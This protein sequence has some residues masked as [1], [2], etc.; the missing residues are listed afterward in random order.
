MS[1]YTVALYQDP[2]G[3]RPPVEPVLGICVSGGGSR[4]MT[5]TLGQLS[6][7]NTLPDPLK[8]SQTLMQRVS[9]L[10][11]VSGGSWAAVPY[12]YLPATI[13]GK[14]VADS[15]ILIAP[16]APSALVKGKPSD[17]SPANV[18]HLAPLCLGTV[19]GGFN[20]EA[21]AGFALH[22]IKLWVW[23]KVPLSWLWIVAVGQFV[24]QKF[25]L[26]EAGYN[27]GVQPSTFFSLSADY[28]STA[29]VPANPQLKPSDFYTA[30]A[31]RPTLVVNFNLLQDIANAPQVPVQATPIATGLPGQSPDG[32]ITGGG[33]CE[34]FGFGSTVSG[35]SS[36]ATATAILARRYSLCDITGCSSAFFAQWLQQHLGPHL[37]AAIA[38][39]EAIPEKFGLAALEIPQVQTKLAELKTQ[40]AADETVAV[41]PQYTVWPVG[42]AA[43]A[44]TS[45]GFSDGGSFDNTGIL[46]LLARTTGDL[47]V[48][49]F[50]NCEAPLAMD[51]KS[52][53]VIVDDQLS[54]LF[55]FAAYDA[56]TGRYP[57]YG[58]MQP[59]QPMSYVQLFADPAA[60]FAELR[61]T[62]AANS[63]AGGSALGNGIA[64][65]RQSLVTIANPVAAIT[66][67]RN[68]DVLWV[69]N[70]PVAAW[71]NQI[72]D[73]AL[74]ADLKQ[75]QGANPSGPL[76]NFPN[77][78]TAS[79]LQ[80]DAEA[81]NMLAQ[82]S[83]WNVGQLQQQIGALLS[84]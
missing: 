3:Q 71:Q 76:A 8:P 62:L 45:Y 44:T 14:A 19:P 64:W 26:Y 50:V 59:S 78:S 79:Q 54:L 35:S 53:E 48:I 65:A 11:S 81:V 55:G 38:D 75:G 36:G 77:F 24:L 82:L 9:Y 6:A 57:S 21:I 4:S 72:T 12:T 18:S 63:R 74:Q 33:A 32:T 68:V 40:L 10:S 37:D 52:G 22:W 43:P 17:S 47:K 49:A 70:N 56:E 16:Q 80:L 39:V 51:S 30:R 34:S 25:G 60:K 13:G 31:G 83:A 58:G 42:A 1:T 84:A 2:I 67:G 20:D 15:D 61:Q 5:C 27:A 29:I 66:A 23:N 46:G 7:L 41:V 28:V 69:Y 73:K